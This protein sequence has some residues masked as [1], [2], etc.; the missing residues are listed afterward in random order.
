MCP[1]L[2]GGH[3]RSH[4]LDDSYPFVPQYSPSGNGR[5][6]AFQD[7]EIGATDG[8]RVDPHDGVGVRLDLGVGDLVP[9]L[10]PWAV[11]D[12]ARMRTSSLQFV[13]VMVRPAP[14]GLQGRKS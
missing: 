12:V 8:H 6:V 1:G 5:H 7:V 2:E 10:V 13:P 11:I 14:P 9:A 4:F 3:T